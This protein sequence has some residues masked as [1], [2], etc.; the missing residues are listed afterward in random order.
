MI[1]IWYC[2]CVN[3]CVYVAYSYGSGIEEVKEAVHDHYI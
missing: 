2:G 1:E 3:V